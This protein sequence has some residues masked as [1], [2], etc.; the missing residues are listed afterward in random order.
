M[1]FAVALLAAAL[2]TQAEAATVIHGTTDID[3][4][5]LNY[6]LY[7]ADVDHFGP[8]LNTVRLDLPSGDITKYAIGFLWQDTYTFRAGSI[9]TTDKIYGADNCQFG[10]ACT[11]FGG[12]PA[13]LANVDWGS[14]FFEF[15]VDLPT[16]HDDCATKQGICAE[17]WQ[18]QDAFFLELSPIGKRN[19]TLTYSGDN[20]TPYPTGE[21]PEPSAWAMMIAGFGVVGFTARLRGH[22]RREWALAD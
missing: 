20:A 15:T 11:G 17:S 8:G 3:S 5:G 22:T 2:A 7:E 14:T 4:T 21:V 13:F 16:P 12:G 9:S 6:V 18:F 19:Y 1:R 10:S